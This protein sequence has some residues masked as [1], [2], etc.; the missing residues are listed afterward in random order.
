ML[1]FFSFF[2]VQ[3]EGKKRTKHNGVIQ[4]PTVSTAASLGTEES[5]RFGEV[6]VIGVSYDNFF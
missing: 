4:S 1:N 2:L 3:V 5:G 6:A